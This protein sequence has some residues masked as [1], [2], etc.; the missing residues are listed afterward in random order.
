MTK[1]LTGK[2]AVITGGAQ[3]LG[4]AFAAALAE[5]GAAV[6]VGDVAATEETCTAIAAAGGQ[7]RGARLDVTSAESVKAVFDDVKKAFGRLD[8][9]VNNAAIS[10]SI[11]LKPMLEVS[12]EEW[13][14][15][16]AV[17]VRGT[18]ECIKA[19]VPLMRLNSYGKIVNLSSGTAVKGAPGLP[20]YV[21]SKGAVISLTRAAARE[22]GP[23]GIRVNALAPGLTMSENMKL[24]PSWSSDVITNNIATRALK[25]EA[26]P[27]D[28][29]GTLIFLASPASDFVTGQ[30]LSVDGGSVMN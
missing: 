14:R 2:V 1:L 8:I 4:A 6:I 23:D 29:L 20:H 16:M 28:L 11:H 25:R 15:V 13:D 9:L 12:S 3:G 18:F 24:N 10:G 26:V 19:A 21:A 27:A 17:N 30:T 5:Q 22:F 7:A